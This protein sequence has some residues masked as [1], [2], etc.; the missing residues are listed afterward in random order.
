[1]TRHGGPAA[2]LPATEVAPI[3]FQGITLEGKVIAARCPPRPSA[4]SY[5]LGGYYEGC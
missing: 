2:L 3:L 4:R 1:M 5:M